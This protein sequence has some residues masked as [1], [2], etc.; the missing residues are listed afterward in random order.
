MSA[1][2]IGDALL[3]EIGAGRGGAIVDLAKLAARDPGD[4][5]LYIDVIPQLSRSHAENFIS[6]CPDPVEVVRSFLDHLG[7]D[8][9][10]RDFK[11]ADRV[12]MLIFW[13]AAFAERTR[14]W[15]LLEEAADALFAWDDHWNQFKPQ[16]A[17]GP[18]LRRLD[19]EGARIVASAIRN[20]SESLQHFSGVADR[21]SDPRIISLLGRT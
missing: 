20:Y 18:W 16:D 1:A 12:I 3:V 21:R 7:G 15:T 14:D 2:S 4:Y 17:I 13:I 19:G 8:W 9:D 5:E 6:A 11:W 10:H